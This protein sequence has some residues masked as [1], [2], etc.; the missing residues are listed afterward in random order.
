MTTPLRSRFAARFSEQDASALEVAG[1]AH[2]TEMSRAERNT[3]S[4]EFGTW[5]AICIGYQC[6]ESENGRAH[7]GFTDDA[8]YDEVKQWIID[9]NVIRDH[10]GDFDALALFCGKYQKFMQPEEP[11]DAD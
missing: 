2:Y 1:L 7:H 6:F 10:D 9:N 4:D 3:G 5:I 8:P 11:T